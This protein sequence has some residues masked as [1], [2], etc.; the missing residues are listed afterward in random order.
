MSISLAFNILPPVIRLLLIPDTLFTVFFFIIYFNFF[1]FPAALTLCFVSPPAT[2]TRN[3]L[4]WPPII[5]CCC[6]AWLP[7]L[8]WTTTWTRRGRRSSST[9]RATHEC[10]RLFEISS[11]QSSSAAAI[12]HSLSYVW[13]MLGRR[14]IFLFLLL[15]CPQPRTTLFWTHK[16]RTQHGLPE[17][18]H[19]EERRRQH[20][21]GW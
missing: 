15:L 5:A 12:S 9:K 11:I 14:K 3:S 10:E 18:I 1:F 8:A 13:Q 2:S 21:Q 7:T 6:I 20:G 4:R 19:I 16:G 17:E